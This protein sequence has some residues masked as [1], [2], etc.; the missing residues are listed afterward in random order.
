M[1]AEK[2]ETHA[3]LTWRFPRVFWFANAAELFERAAFYG[4]FIA[5][6]LYLT[7]RVGFS[8]VHAGYLSAGFSSVLY[9]LPTFLGAMA[10]KIGFRR[11]LILAFALLAAG[12]GLLGAFQLKWTAVVALGLVM[13]GGAIVKPVISGTVAY[14]SDENHRAR[15][16]SIFYMV[17]NIGS[18][19]GKTAAK[20]LRTGMELPYFGRVEL[21]LE[22]INFY[23]AAMALAALLVVVFVYRDVETAGV[24]KSPREAWR[25]L[26]KVV[27]NLRFMALIFIIAGFWIIQGQ[28]YAT[29][30][31]Y[32][33]R[34]IGESASPEWLANINPFV[35]VLCV[36]PIT[37]VIRHFKPEN[38]IA[39]AMLIIPLSA[40]S[41]SLSPVL[42]AVAGDSVEI[43]G[44]AFHP[45]T[46]MVII[47]VGFQGLAEC[48]LSPKWLEFASRQAP[49]GEQG[50]YLGY[51]NLT[52]FVAWFLGFGISGHLLER[53][54]P[55][56]ET[57]PAASYAQ[58]RKAVDYGHRFEVEGASAGEMAVGGLVPE[59]VRE[60]FARHGMPLGEG[61]TIESVDGGLG[62]RIEAEHGTYVL[63]DRGGALAVEKVRRALPAEYAEA[64]VIWT[65]FAGIGACAF[66]AMLVFKLVTN[67]LDRARMVPEP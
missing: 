35:V 51:Q 16:F 30:P 10:D 50:L 28:L 38:A 1:M 44:V 56:P 36:V 31:K 29:M 66:L 34:L 48:F 64:H 23:A 54:C 5:L 32:L 49:R 8:D 42:R 47:G 9:L 24:G 41:I 20:P 26:L 18:F 45:I 46:V 17:V 52:T 40:L 2:I 25:G 55:D 60:A 15:A 58:W 22:Y 11:A 27:R 21:G 61:A 65:I 19:T 43:L 39:L 3:A 33:T 4:M 7:R 53:Y 6:T 63:A 14:C 59:V 62:W 37:H 12:Y 57:L 67:A 13:V